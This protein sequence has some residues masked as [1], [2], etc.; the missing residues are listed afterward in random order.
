[1]SI[2]PLL[3]TW[4]IPKSCR[5]PYTRVSETRIYRKR[6]LD[7]PPPLIISRHILIFLG[8]P[9]AAPGAI[10]FYFRL[11]LFSLVSSPCYR[12]SFFEVRRPKFGIFR[13]SH[14]PA[15]P[16]FFFQLPHASPD[17]FYGWLVGFSRS[18]C[19]LPI[20][21]PVSS[22]PAPQPLLGPSVRY[23]NSTHLLQMGNSIGYSHNSGP[24]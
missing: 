5:C 14:L 20:E 22:L 12:P 10:N 11:D 17:P 19:F 1:M 4:I 13:D 2:S 9:L 16:L 3:S 15:G 6:P 7:P 23:L 8:P 21:P 24:L 18:S